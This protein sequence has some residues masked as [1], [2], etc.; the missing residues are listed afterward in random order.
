MIR[1]RSSLDRQLIVGTTIMLAVT[2]LLSGGLVYTIFGS[3]VGADHTVKA[4]AVFRQALMAA[5]RI[6]VERGPT[7]DLLDEED[8]ADS[9]THRK[10]V[11]FRD[12]TDAALKATL[13]VATAAADDIGETITP[14]GIARIEARLRL[15]RAA[16]DALAAEP[17]ARRVPERIADVNSD[18]F[19]AFDAA[20]RLIDEEI[21]NLSAKQPALAGPAMVAQILSELREYAGRAG[22]YVFPAVAI[23]QPLS[24]EAGLQLMRTFGRIDELW[25]L[26]RHQASH[27]SRSSDLVQ[28]SY[29]VEARFFTVGLPMLQAA[30]ASL[31]DNP[32]TA[33]AIADLKLR[34]FA[35]TDSIERLS[36]AFLSLTQRAPE[37]ERDTALLRLV[38]VSLLTG[39][40]V[41]VNVGLIFGARR[42]VLVPLLTVREHII[43]LAEGRDAPIAATRGP[44]EMQ[45]LFE[46]LGTLSERVRE[47]RRYAEDLRIQAETDGLTGL[48]NR[49]S[50]DRIGNGDPAYADLPEDVGLIMLDLDHFKE[51]NDR[52]GHPVG[53]R[54]LR[55]VAQV[56]LSRISERDIAARYGGDE[57]A[58]VVASGPGWRVTELAEKLNRAIS[59]ASIKL[60]DGSDLWITASIGVAGGRRGTQSWPGVIGAADDALYRA[61]TFGRNRVA[62]APPPGVVPLGPAMVA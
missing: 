19:D 36:L 33:P 28:A 4:L 43:A 47:R 37:R 17:L 14:N 27:Y 24:S 13:S 8:T 12:A 46:A 10:L 21:V 35:T 6:S 22:S 50:F 29:D 1:C 16:T 3:Y 41:F 5:H 26:A 31:N 61:K 9:P 20:K 39:M 32:V 42:L 62:E 59:D 58:I 48:A 23:R 53:D 25:Q 11:E 44:S 40:V 54:V 2:L 15:A 45:R 38:A 30:A 57:I 51:V 49:Q 60:D 18:M 56:I 52:H 7:N 34:Y 55:Q